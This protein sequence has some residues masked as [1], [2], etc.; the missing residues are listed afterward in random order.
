MPGWRSKAFAQIPQKEENFLSWCTI[1]T[2][3]NKIYNICFARC[4]ISPVG[5]AAFT[6]VG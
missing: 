1:I 4:M 2:I 6:L 5:A 3:V